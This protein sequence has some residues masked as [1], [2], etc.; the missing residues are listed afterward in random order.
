MNERNHVIELMFN[1]AE[2]ALLMEASL[3]NCNSL[4]VYMR[5]SLLEKAEKDLTRQTFLNLNE[6]RANSK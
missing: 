6:Q 5:L 3:L 2:I 1:S 4:E